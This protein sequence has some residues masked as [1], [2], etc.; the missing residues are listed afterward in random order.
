MNYERYRSEASDINFFGRLEG[1][2][3]SPFVSAEVVDLSKK[4]WQKSDFQLA[5]WHV[6]AED[7]VTY[8]SNKGL[9][10]FKSRNQDGIYEVLYEPVAYELGK[11][12]LGLDYPATTA[13][14]FFNNNTL[15]IGTL[16]H[17]FFTQTLH[18][19]SSV[20]QSVFF[21][22]LDPYSFLGETVAAIWY[23]NWDWL[24]EKYDSVIF[25]QNLSGSSAYYIIDRTHIFKGPRGDISQDQLK[26]YEINNVWW[27]NKNNSKIK[28]ENCLP[29]VK[30]IERIPDE[31][32][33]AI[34]LKWA[35]KIGEIDNINKNRY[36]RM[37]ED[38][39]SY[40]IGNK[41]LVRQELSAYFNH[42][43]LS[44]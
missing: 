27:W 44:I 34:C 2:I 15:I 32:I 17:A 11:K 23:R 42:G 22:R 12:Y 28:L 43:I 21:K 14:Y 19:A 3:D 35:D 10:H 16:S 36:L 41:W 6:H 24:G 7:H 39:A 8:Q 9:V 29:F 20:F 38:L 37:A 4:N 31:V 25:G 5:K 33:K 13:S 26:N 40:L 18:T 1:S 30:K